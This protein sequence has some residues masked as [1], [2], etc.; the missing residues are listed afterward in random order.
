MLKRGSIFAFKL[1]FLNT[2]FFPLFGMEYRVLTAATSFP[3]GI[4][5]SVGP[6][7]TVYQH[8]NFEDS[9]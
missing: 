7:F 6:M 9:I 5:E 3:H 8:R 1:I 4:T 2:P